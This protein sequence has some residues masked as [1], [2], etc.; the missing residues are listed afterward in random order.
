M[1]DRRKVLQLGPLD[2]RRIGS[3]DRFE[4]NALGLSGPEVGIVPGG[5]GLVSPIV[6]PVDRLLVH[7]IVRRRGTGEARSVGRLPGVLESAKWQDG[8]RNAAGRVSM[9]GE[10]VDRRSRGG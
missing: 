9:R 1:I 3:D 2:V 8:I 10:V 7:V 4:D 5:L 6:E